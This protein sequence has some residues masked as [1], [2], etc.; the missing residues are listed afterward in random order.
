MINPPKVIR[1]LI[2]S[3]P[4]VHGDYEVTRGAKGLIVSIMDK[5]LGGTE[6][7]YLV[8][9]WLFDFPGIKMSSKYLTDVQWRGLI[10]WINPAKDTETGEWMTPVNLQQEM[11]L[12]YHEA[13]ERFRKDITPWLKAGIDPDTYTAHGP[14]KEVR[15]VVEDTRKAPLFS[16]IPEGTFDDDGITS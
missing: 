16:F 12:V 6:A 3:G 11:N 9:A 2:R 4:M 5:M 15:T 8:L 13:S 10:N 1:D 7:R 14:D